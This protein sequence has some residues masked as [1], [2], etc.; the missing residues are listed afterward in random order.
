LISS[1][2]IA[3]TSLIFLGV[4]EESRTIGKNKNYVSFVACATL[5]QGRKLAEIDVNSPYQLASTVPQVPKNFATITNA[6]S[7]AQSVK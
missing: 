1:F 3:R 2:E 5:E 7:I 4:F 6:V